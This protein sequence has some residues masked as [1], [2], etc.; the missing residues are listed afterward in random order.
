S[1]L[2]FCQYLKLI[3]NPESQDQWWN[4]VLDGEFVGSALSSQHTATAQQTLIS[5]DDDKTLRIYGERY[6]TTGTLASE[7]TIVNS[8]AEEDL[9]RA[10]LRRR[11][12]AGEAGLTL[13][14]RRF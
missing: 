4:R 13:D 14:D 12:R 10:L 7:W 3:P 1:H 5:R 9:A 2:S 11:R 8:A 6:Y